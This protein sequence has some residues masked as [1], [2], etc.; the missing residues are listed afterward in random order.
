MHKVAKSPNIPVRKTSPKIIQ[1]NKGDKMAYLNITEPSFD[2]APQRGNSDFQFEELFVSES[3][4]FD[5]KPSLKDSQIISSGDELSQD[6]IESEEVTNPDIG[7]GE[8]LELA[9]SKVNLEDFQILKVIGK[10]AYG[11]VFQVLQKS[12]DQIY[13]MKVLRKDFLIKTKNV[14]YTKTEKDILRTVRHPYIVSLHYA[15]QNEG[16][17]YLVMDYM[18]VPFLIFFFFL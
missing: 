4:Q 9:A 12:T 8:T 1:N 5:A 17:V 18:N 15:F 7:E 10:G 3:V 6:K 13:A 11:K 16:R 14:T 2:F